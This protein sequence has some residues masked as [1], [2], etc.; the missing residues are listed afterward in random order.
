MQY[1]DQEKWFSPPIAVLGV[2]QDVKP[3]SGPAAGLHEESEIV[4]NRL[5][6]PRARGTILWPSDLPGDAR[7][8]CRTM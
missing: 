2:L 6:V 1:D 4:S 8:I 7:R 3:M 5:D